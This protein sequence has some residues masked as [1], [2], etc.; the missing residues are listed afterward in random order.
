MMRSLLFLF[1]LA[2]VCLWAQDKRRPN[3]NQRAKQGIQAKF[4]DKQW[5]L[6]FKAG[7]NLTDAKPTQRYSILTPT[8][9]DPALNNKVYDAFTE[10]GF[11]ATVEASFS[12]KGFLFSAQPTY[13]QSS[14]SYANEFEWD[15]PENSTDRLLLKYSQ[16]Q[17]LDYLD[18]PFIVKYEVAGNKLRPYLQAGIFYSLLLNATKEVVVSGTDFASG[19]T[20]SFQNEALIIG[21]KDLFEN[22]WGVLA[23]AGVNYNL[24]NVRLTLD[25]SYRMGQSNIANIRN[26]FSNDRLNG[27]GDAQD[28]L[29]IDNIVVSVGCLFPLRFLASS[30]KSVD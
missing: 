28:D 14:F 7:S 21:A 5:W 23:G 26:R 22:Y 3:Y 10:Y 8:N 6:G 12:F 24:G 29:E 4:L 11:Q 15:N 16:L 30:F 13:R 9:Y 25:A 20:N 19:G 18:L 2:P 27:I 17:R 1:L